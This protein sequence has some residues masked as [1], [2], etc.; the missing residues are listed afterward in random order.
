[1]AIGT[2]V[3]QKFNL[4]ERIQKKE[5]IIFDRDEFGRIATSKVPQRRLYH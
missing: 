1:M 4:A 5:R 2:I 3:E